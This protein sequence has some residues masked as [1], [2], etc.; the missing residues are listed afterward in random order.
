MASVNLKPVNRRALRRYGEFWRSLQLVAAALAQAE[1][2][3][4]KAADAQPARASAG[5]TARWS[6]PTAQELR[7]SAKKAGQALHVMASAAKKW[8]A[9]LVSRE[10]RR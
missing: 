10:W 7:S 8:E 2:V 3:A 9:E 5:A 6:A 1:L 4:Q